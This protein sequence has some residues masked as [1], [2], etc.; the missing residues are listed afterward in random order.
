MAS[1][2]WTLANFLSNCEIVIWSLES[3]APVHYRSFARWR[4]EGS[5]QG[6]RHT[7]VKQSCKTWKSCIL[8]FA[9]SWTLASMIMCRTVPS[10]TVRSHK[11]SFQ[12]GFQIIYTLNNEDWDLIIHIKVQCIVF[13][14]A[15]LQ[16][17]R[18]WKDSREHDVCSSVYFAHKYAAYL[19]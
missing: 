6:D 19:V 13:V 15:R 18:R 14:L 10:R 8:C 12:S 5:C 9:L 1:S 16:S 11:Q 2:M 3:T 17:G 4:Q 7:L